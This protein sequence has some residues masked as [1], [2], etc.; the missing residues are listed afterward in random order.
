LINLVQRVTLD[1]IDGDLLF[2]LV[3]VVVVV[4]SFRLLLLV[5]AAAFV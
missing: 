2:L 4:G 3:D 5:V 1:F